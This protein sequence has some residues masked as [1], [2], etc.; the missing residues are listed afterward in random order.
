MN[1]LSFET[2]LDCK[3]DLK[4]L[5]RALKKLGK[6]NVILDVPLEDFAEVFNKYLID[7]LDIDLFAY[8]VSIERNPFIIKIDMSFIK[9]DS[10][11]EYDFI[12]SELK[13]H[14]GKSIVKVQE[15]DDE[16]IG[17]VNIRAALRMMFSEASELEQIG[18]FIRIK[19]NVEE[20]NEDS[21]EKYFLE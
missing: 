12:I 11:Q 17:T 9:D 15:E 10:I 3:E 6:T 4:L 20:I 7:T 2:E 21:F 8:D 18:K 5:K 14:F 19:I 1:V 16:A 13:K